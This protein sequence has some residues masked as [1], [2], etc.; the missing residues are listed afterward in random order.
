MAGLGVAAIEFGLRYLDWPA[1]V[2]SGWRLTSA[3]GP[4]NQAGWRG[5]KWHRL[6]SDFVAVLTGGDEVECV[7]CPPGETVDLIL[8]RA[9]QRYNP[10]ARVVT[11]G[12]RCYAQDQEL[13]GLLE[14]FRHERADLVIDWAVVARDVPANVFRTGSISPGVVVWKPAYT[15]KDHVLA[16]PTEEIGEPVFQGKLVTLLLS[17]FIRPG[18]TWNWGLPE[19][20]A[21]T[22][23]PPPGVETKS[24]VED[25]LDQQR[26]GWS[27]S[28][29][30][31]PPRV[32]Y[33]IELT[34][35]LLGR[36]R[37]VATLHGARF[38]V[39]VTP[40]AGEGTSKG[41]IALEHDGR[42]FL[43]SPGLRD[44]AIADVTKGLDRITED[45]AVSSVEDERRVMEKLAAALNQRELLGAAAQVRH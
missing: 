16:G 32:S 15:L 37:D 8:E 18:V 3:E 10:N 19:A 24:H 6:P 44:A 38:S 28:L 23:E 2:I 17:P 22:T 40:P 31:R 14:F 13:L 4:V 29:T 36:M 9:L 45:T 41:P 43:A 26:S 11:L 34:R 33:G 27:I 21:G 25:A 20:V 5:Q 39:L 1:P 7:R 35:L 12:S 30:P 42:W